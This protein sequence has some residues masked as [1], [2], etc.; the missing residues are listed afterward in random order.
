VENRNA[1]DTMSARA[2]LVP[3]TPAIELG[4][5]LYATDFSEASL[6]ALPLVSTIAR[7]YRSRVFVTHIWTPYP[8]TMVTPETAADLDIRDENEARARASALLTTP[9][10]KG[11]PATV[12]LESGNPTAELNRLVR[13]QDI[14]LVIVSTHGRT[15]F[16]HLLMGSVAEELFRS[17]PCPVLTV[18]PN[19]S[20]RSLDITEIRHILFP[21]DLSDESRTVFPYLASLAAEYRAALTLLS[22]LPIETAMNADAKN[23]PE[24]LQKEMQKIFSPHIDPRSPA[25]FLVDFGD[26]AERILA[27]AE[28]ANADLIGLGVRRA[29]EITTHFRNTVAYRVLLGAHCPVLISGPA[30]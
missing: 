2:V 28:A 21:T 6:V 23:L 20:K 25:E 4:R 15:G 22:V 1:G 16:K 24:P 17:L 8:Y 27:H 10:L 9:E 5:I 19:V 11:L 7:K 26:T 12:V 18:G 30:D 13:E 29:P 14:D 3:I